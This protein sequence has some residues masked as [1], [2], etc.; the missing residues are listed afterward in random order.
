MFNLTLAKL[1]T[2]SL[3]SSLNARDGWKKDSN[4]VN[5][6][7]ASRP[8]G[9]AKLFQNTVNIHFFSVS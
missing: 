6:Y 4:P 3:I 7:D 8:V 1:Y 2:N 5:D 9:Q